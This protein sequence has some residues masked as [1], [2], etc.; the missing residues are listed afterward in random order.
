[1]CPENIMSSYFHSLRVQ[2]GKMKILA[3]INYFKGVT[4]FTS[5]TTRKRVESRPS[6]K[7][8]FPAYY[9]KLVTLKAI[10]TQT[11]SINAFSHVNIIGI[12][13]LLGGAILYMTGP[14]W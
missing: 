11:K 8:S 9:K 3:I 7:A 4:Y 6:C 12:T 10:A 5:G 14:L 2:T 1:M 13:K